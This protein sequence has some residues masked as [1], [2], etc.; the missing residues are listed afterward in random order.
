MAETA[1][2]ATIIPNQII[3]LEYVGY[4]SRLAISW[5]KKMII[6]IK[7]EEVVSNENKELL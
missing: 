4:L 7:K 6:K 5:E 3:Y 1:S 2:I